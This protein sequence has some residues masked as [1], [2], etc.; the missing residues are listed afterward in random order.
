VVLT[1]YQIAVPF[2]AFLA[3]VYAWNLVLRQKKTIWEALLW[4]LFW[5]GVGYVALEPGALT[6]LSVI[7]GVKNQVNAF[8][9]TAIGIL[10]FLLFYVIVR[11]EE[12]NQRQSKLVRMLALKTADLDKKSDKSE[13]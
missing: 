7:T 3:M 2:L 11:L 8:F 9:A 10:F 6:Y 5:G 13:R 12:L 1:P 4:T